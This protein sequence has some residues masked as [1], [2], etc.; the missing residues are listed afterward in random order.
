LILRVL[1]GWELGNDGLYRKYWSYIQFLKKIKNF[2]ISFWSQEPKKHIFS[3]FRISYEK[4]KIRKSRNRQP[5]GPEPDPAPREAEVME[6]S[7]KLSTEGKRNK[8]NKGNVDAS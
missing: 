7:R 5:A 8:K 3:I 4:K 1:E 6:G 2:K